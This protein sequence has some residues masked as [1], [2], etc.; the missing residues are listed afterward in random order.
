MPKHDASSS[1]QGPS[2]VTWSN[3]LLLLRQ[4]DWQH[5][6]SRKQHLNELSDKLSQGGP[7]VL[8]ASRSQVLMGKKTCDACL[9]PTVLTQ[10]AP[11]RTSS[12]QASSP[13]LLTNPSLLPS[14][15]QA[16]HSRSFAALFQTSRMETGQPDTGAAGG[17]PLQ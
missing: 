13:Y 5:I 15:E 2:S 9:S 16:R 1:L 14:P 6:S 12:S 7:T 4:Q 8:T 10:S 17:W 3:A 11:G